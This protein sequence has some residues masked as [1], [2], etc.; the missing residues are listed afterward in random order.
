VS[1]T[2]HCLS[3]CLQMIASWQ[4]AQNEDTSIGS[5][6]NALLYTLGR[7]LMRH[8]KAQTVGGHAVS[9]LPPKTEEAAAGDHA[10]DQPIGLGPACCFCSV[11]I[12]DTAPPLS[13]TYHH[14]Q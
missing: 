11:V 5:G 12:P 10:N 13:T 9:Q 7:M 8:T 2:D 6:T 1:L 3:L 14:L 4:Q